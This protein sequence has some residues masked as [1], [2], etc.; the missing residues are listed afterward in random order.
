MVLLLPTV[1]G[2]NNHNWDKPRAL[3][4]DLFGIINL[5]ALMLVLCSPAEYFLAG[6]E[7]TFRASQPGQNIL[8]FSPGKLFLVQ[9]GFL[10]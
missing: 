8:I 9:S 5:Q 6:K 3:P 1:L 4:I 10:I 2:R 7:A